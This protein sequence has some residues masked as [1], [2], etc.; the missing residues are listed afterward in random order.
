[1]TRL[2]PVVLKHLV[3]FIREMDNLRDAG[4]EVIHFSAL[5][6]DSDVQTFEDEVMY[7]RAHTKDVEV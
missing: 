4:A 2:S 5:Y 1:M 3:K 6:G 7:L